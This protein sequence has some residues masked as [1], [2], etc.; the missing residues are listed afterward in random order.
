MLIDKYRFSLFNRCPYIEI[1]SQ[2]SKDYMRNLI[3]YGTAILGRSMI[4][5]DFWL[6]RCAA[7]AFSVSLWCIELLNSLLTLNNKCDLQQN[8]KEM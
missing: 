6:L 8:R 5:P 3:I 2:I 1:R 7:R 4:K